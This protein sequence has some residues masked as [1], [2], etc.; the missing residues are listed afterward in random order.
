M[1]PCRLDVDLSDMQP[2]TAVKRKGP[3]CF[4]VFIIWF[5]AVDHSV[6]RRAGL[7]SVFI[8][9]LIYARTS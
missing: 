5:V 1:L 9:R 3:C 4:R 6:P 8:G 2:C 7:F